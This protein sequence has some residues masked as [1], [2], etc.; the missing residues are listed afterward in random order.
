MIEV[1]GSVELAP[2]IGLADGDRR[3]HGDR[4][5]RC[6]RTASRSA[7]RSSTVT[8]RL[9][10][11]RV[12]HKLR[13]D[14]DRRARRARCGRLA[15]RAAARRPGGRGAGRGRDPRAGAGRRAA[16]AAEVAAIV[17]RRARRRRRGA[18]RA[19]RERFD[20]ADAAPLRVDRGG[21]RRGA[22]GARRRASAPRCELAIANVRAVAARRA[23]R[24]TV[25]VEL[26]QGQRQRLREVP[27]AARRR[28]TRPAAAPPTRRSVVMGAV[29]AAG[30]RASTRSSSC[31]A[32]GGA[33]GASSPRARSAASTRSTRWAAP[34]RSPRSPTAPR[35]SPRV[36]V[37]VGPGQPLGPGGQAAGL[38]R[39]SGSTA[40]PAPATLL[41]VAAEGADAGAR[42]ARP[43]RP[44]RAR[45]RRLARRSPSA[46][47]AGAARRRRA[48]RLARRADDSG[49]ALALVGVPGRRATALAL[50]E[51]LAPEH[52]RARSGA[53]AEAL[54]PQRALAPA[55]SSS[56]R[57]GAT[58]FGDY[59]AGS[60]HVLPTGGAGALRLGPLGAGALPPPHERG[61][62]S[63][64]PRP[65][66]RRAGAAIARAEGFAVH[67]RVAWRYGRMGAHEPHARD[68]PQDRRDPDPPRARPRRR[69]RRRAPRPASASSTTC[70]TCSPATGGSA[71]TSRSSG[72]LETGSHHTVE[73]IGIA[74]GQALDEALG[75]RAG[76]PPLRPRRR[77]DGRGARASARSTSP[78]GRCSSFDADLPPAAIAGFEPSW[79]RSSSAPSR[80]P[81]S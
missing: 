27:G 33:P 36:D 50:A 44:G 10:A 46:S 72:D 25:D 60:N 55:A 26:P 76:H 73:D 68:R 70:S 37:I 77:A 80:A 74:L 19:S 15:T 59:V 12:A 69:R 29:T 2:L 65:R 66:W 9:I 34:R 52:L 45:R 62:R 30:R 47:D 23:R 54:A 56:A 39:R 17:A 14:G 6:A 31:A 3:P 57:A 40:S 22:R 1:K 41:V 7:R 38:R 75:D 63:A 42:R 51:A 28:S 20:G 53:A 18:A 5:R 11:N 24:A 48:T 32:G 81:R 13:A 67:A 64:T 71:S 79:P 78:A 61:P 49:A 21:A 43:L 58:A 35:R 16:I 4:A 8:A